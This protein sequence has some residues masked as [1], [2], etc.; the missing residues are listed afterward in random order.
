MKNLGHF[1]VR[2]CLEFFQHVEVGALPH[3]DR[4]LRRLIRIGWKNTAWV[5]W[6]AV[7]FDD[8]FV[9]E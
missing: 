2:N 9:D 4:W 6:I 5:V 1:A 3:L 7:W 8:G